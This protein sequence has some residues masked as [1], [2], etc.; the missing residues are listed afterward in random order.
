[1]D[2]QQN[3]LG[4]VFLT[5]WATALGAGL[6]PG[7]SIQTRPNVLLLISDDLRA[8][9]GCYGAPVKSPNVDALAQRGVRIDHAYCQYPLCGPSRC[10][11]LSG[12]RPD[13]NGV[14]SNGLTVRYKLK[15]V[16]T[17]PQHF[18]NQGYFS[19]RCGKMYHLGIPEQVGQPGP[20]DPPS[21]DYTFNPK[22]NEYPS[23]DDGDEFD[24]DP[25]NGQSF[26]RNL[27]NGNGAD[28]ADWQI[29]DEAIRLLNQHKDHPFFLGVGFIRPH[30]PEIAPR[31]FF[32]MYDRAEVHLPPRPANDRA[33]KPEFA[34]RLGTGGA[35]VDMGMSQQDCLESIRAYHAA[36]SFMDEQLGRVVAELDRLKLA[37]KTI[38]VFM[39]DHG[40]L[41]GEHFAWQKKMLFEKTCRVPM[42]VI[43]PAMKARGQVADGLVEL[44]DLFPTL[45]ELAGLPPP[46]GLDGKS[47]VP[48][49]EQP[50]R[51][52]K[53]AAF[54]MIT[55]DIRKKDQPPHTGRSIRTDRWRYT[56]WDGGQNG[57]EL[58]DE[59]NDPI[60]AKNLANDATAAATLANLREQLHA[61]KASIHPTTEP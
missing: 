54:S 36:T 60:E 58:Y 24:P 9:L 49:L 32:E 44:V 45:V 18:R 19:A 53:Q 39:S 11:F 29:A 14:Y 56:E 5:F 23:R 7:A 50:Q 46:P 16:V 10:S 59:V 48:L 1:M 25:K 2:Y 15:D 26:R 41:L 17:L 51:P 20:D 33:D 40:Y 38:I 42:I 55:T 12:L 34:F 47:F 61:A 35:K 52:F 31:K 6:A 3:R 13:T 30:V 4:W 21:W 22:G 57:A 37:D 27:L 43:Y 28:Q 8:D